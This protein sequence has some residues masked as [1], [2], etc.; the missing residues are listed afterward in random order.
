MKRTILTILS[1]LALSAC[2]RTTVQCPAGTKPVQCS[3]GKSEPSVT[4]C[5]ATWDEAFDKA[6]ALLDPDGSVPDRSLMCEPH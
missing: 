5:A 6:H 4:V 2:G 3:Y 1:I